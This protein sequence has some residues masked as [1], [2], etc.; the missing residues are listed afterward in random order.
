MTDFEF[1]GGLHVRKALR[2]V[3]P[4]LVRLLSRGRAHSIPIVYVNDNPGPWR[5]DAPSLIRRC[6]A[7]RRALA[8]FDRLMPEARDFILLKPRHSGFYGTPLEPLLQDLKVDTLILMGISTESCVWM[9]ACD[10]YTR[11]FDLVVPKDTAAGLS[12]KAVAATLTG[13]T[14]ALGARTPAA[15]SSVKFRRGRLA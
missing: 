5:S 7:A 15:A 1:P 4:A 13:L 12:A 3:T 11:G 6:K 2:A 8:E 9:T 10:A 14:T